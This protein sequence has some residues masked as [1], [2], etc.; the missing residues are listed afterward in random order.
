MYSTDGLGAALLTAF[1]VGVVLPI[2]LNAVI[3]V[4]CGYFMAGLSVVRSACWSLLLSVAVIILE[5][6]F[7]AADTGY[8][9]NMAWFKLSI[10]ILVGAVATYLSCRW[11]N[12][13]KLREPK[14]E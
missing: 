14:N 11:W 13:E 6:L 7:L 2:M 10:P 8:S 4:L 12:G 9:E 5:I 3:G 1:L